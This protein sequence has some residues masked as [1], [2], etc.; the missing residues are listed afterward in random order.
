MPTFK[1]YDVSSL[2]IDLLVGDTSK[3]KLFFL[4]F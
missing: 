4:H 1:V 3:D 2:N